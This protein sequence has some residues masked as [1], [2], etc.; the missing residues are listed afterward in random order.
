ME[1]YPAS[2]TFLDHTTVVNP[3]TTERFKAIV[4]YVIQVDEDNVNSVDGTADEDK[5]KE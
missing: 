4:T 1:R 2:E 3:S 5:T